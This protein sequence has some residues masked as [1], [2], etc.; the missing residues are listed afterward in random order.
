MI[1]IRERLRL[2]IVVTLLVLVLNVAGVAAGWLHFPLQGGDCP[3]G[4][5]ARSVTA[6]AQAHQL[7]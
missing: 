7:M 5:S 1:T 2:L 3:D 6:P 4:V